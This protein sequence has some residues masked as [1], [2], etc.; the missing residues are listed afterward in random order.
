MAERPT[1][2]DVAT[3][4]MRGLLRYRNTATVQVVAMLVGG[5]DEA[6]AQ[7]HADLV[8]LDAMVLVDPD[9][10]ELWATRRQERQEA[11]DRIRAMTTLVRQATERAKQEIE[12][13]RS[14]GQEDEQHEQPRGDRGN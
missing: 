6:A 7:I 1:D 8:T 9:F 5:L 10:D 11:L 13:P 14:K 4:A 12:H 2:L 3:R